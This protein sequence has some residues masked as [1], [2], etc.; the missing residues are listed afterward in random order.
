MK[1]ELAAPAQ[2]W[3]LLSVLGDEAVAYLKTLK[4]EQLE[5]IGK[6]IAWMGKTERT[7]SDPIQGRGVTSSS[8]DPQR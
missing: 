1:I 3:F 8:T 5:S 6:L 2:G 7:A 4:P